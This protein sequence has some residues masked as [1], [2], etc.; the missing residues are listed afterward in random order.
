MG[1]STRPSSVFRKLAA[2]MLGATA[3]LLFA[4]F[5]MD[6]PQSTILVEGPVAESQLQL[7][8]VTLWVTVFIFLTVG[9]ALAYAQIR[10]RARKTD[11]DSDPPEQTHG[12]PIV[13]VGLIIAST[14]LLVVIAVP[15]V[16][17]IWYTYDVP[18]SERDS[19]LVV[20][21]TGYQWWFKFEYPE[22]GIVT[23]NEMVIPTNRAIHI[24][25]RTIDVIHSFWVPKLAGKVDLIPNRANHM[26]LKA[27]RANYYWAQCAEYCGES[28]A[29]MRFRVISLD[30]NE[31][32]TWVANQQKDART[33]A[34]AAAS[35]AG[36]VDQPR[37][38]FVAAQPS[39]ED[40]GMAGSD[41]PFAYWQ[42]KQALPAP[43][44]ENAALIAKGR[45][46]F[47]QKTCG[48]C[49][50]INGHAGAVGITGPSLTHFASRTTL[51]A[52]LIDNTPANLRRWLDD[53]NGVKPG[54]LMWKTGG[55]GDPSKIKLKE[56]E[57]D[58]LVAYLNSL[59]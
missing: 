45:E 58:A 41:S 44:A 2:L 37:L 33:V 40:R 5:D 46:L 50:Q 39:E 28:H 1:R 9:G 29:N 35:A 25:L 22:L 54:N 56:D 4:G 14:L 47:I 8:Y 18:E 23:A 26:W 13:E 48:G 52:A 24:D 10:F 34:P 21:V 55:I 31:W 15:T 57:L 42:F 38:Q 49:H 36:L 12:H 43:G 51:A 11:D 7:F 59:K 53:P 27:D 32:N 17:G 6:G 30:G 20:K 3:I 16:R 19:A